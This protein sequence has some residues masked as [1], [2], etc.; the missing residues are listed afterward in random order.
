M[1]LGTWFRDYL[2]FPLGG[3]RVKKPRMIFNL[4]VVWFL[5]GFWHGASW[6][7]IIWG[8]Y[9]GL[10][11]MLEKLTKNQ[12]EKIPF[13]FRHIY[14][15]VVVNVGFVFFKF[16][17]F[18]DAIEYLKVMFSTSGKLTSIDDNSMIFNNIFW[19]LIAVVLC[20]PVM[21]YFER[22]YVR[23]TRGNTVLN[24]TLNI[25]R[26]ILV[27]AL[28]LFSTA[29]LTGNSFNPFLYDAF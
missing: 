5:T 21:K 26:V 17:H 13:F 22:L 28:I 2:Y 6:N 23:S 7:F 19:I 25:L 20:T 14:L 11:I 10:F 29:H 15:L 8:L 12:F 4:F 27:F 3:S 18:S 24:I 1:S 9:N 16:T